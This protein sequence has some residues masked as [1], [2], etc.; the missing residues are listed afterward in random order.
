[1]YLL[2]LVDSHRGNCVLTNTYLKKDNNHLLVAP[3]MENH[4]HPTAK[5]EYKQHVIMKHIVVYYKYR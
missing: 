1:M 4:S 2:W 3:E 5:N